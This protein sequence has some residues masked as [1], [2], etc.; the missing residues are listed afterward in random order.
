MPE[1]ILCSGCFRDNCLFNGTSNTSE[2]ELR[3]Q[4]QAFIN[5]HK[6]FYFAQKF[7]GDF[8]LQDQPQEFVV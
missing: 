8:Q 4:L 2:L 7:L 3:P 5:G 6:A 1:T